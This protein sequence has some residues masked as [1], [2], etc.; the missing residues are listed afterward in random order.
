MLRQIFTNLVL[1]L[2]S[3]SICFIAC[4]IVIVIKRGNFIA[5][6]V[7]L[8]LVYIPLTLIQGFILITIYKRRKKSKPEDKWEFFLPLTIGIIAILIFFYFL[9][10]TS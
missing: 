1:N 9:A 2:L 5:P 6:V 8:C 10:T 7:Y 4:I 3:F